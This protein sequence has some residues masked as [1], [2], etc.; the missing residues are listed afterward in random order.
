MIIFSK[1]FVVLIFI[2][3]LIAAPLAGLV[4][5]NWLQNFEYKIPLQWFMFATG[6]LVTLLIAFITV[7]YRSIRAATANPVDSLRSE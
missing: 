6:V 7:A 5:K 2:A 1:E 4:M 3:F